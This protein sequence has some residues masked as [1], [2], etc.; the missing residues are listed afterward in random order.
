MPDRTIILSL[1]VLFLVFDAIRT[2]SAISF[3]SKRTGG[4]LRDISTKTDIMKGISSNWLLE[5]VKVT[6]FYTH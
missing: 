2:S 6:V 5:A 1:F 3:L 4:A